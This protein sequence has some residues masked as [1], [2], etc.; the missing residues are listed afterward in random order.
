MPPP[1]PPLPMGDATGDG[2]VKRAGMETDGGED[3]LS[4]LPDD[5]LS[6]IL[7]R[8]GSTASAGQTSLLSRRWRR[9][10]SR[11]P[12]LLF[13]FPS[14]PAC[15]GPGIAANTAPFLRHV[16]VVCCDAPAGATTTWLHLLAPRVALDGVVYFRNTL[17]RRRVM[18]VAVVRGEPG[19]PHRHRGVGIVSPTYELPC[20]AT[21]AKLW[22]RLEFLNLEL[23]RSG[24]FA[25]L[26]ELFL[27]HVD[28]NHKGRGNFGH[29]FSTLRCPLL[30]RLRIAMCTGVDTLGIYSESLHHFELEFVPGLMELTLLTPNLRMLEVLSCFY[31]IEEWNCSIHAPDLESLRWGDRFNLD[32]VLFVDFACFQQLAAFT[33]PVYGRPDNTIILEFALLLRHFSAVYRLDLL[34]S[35]ERD[36]DKYEYLMEYITKL[37]IMNTMSLWLYTRGHSVGTS[38]FYLLSLCP[39]VKRLQLT[40]L[41]GIVANSPCHPHCECDQHP[42]WSE[43]E[44]IVHGLEEAEIRNF[45]GTKHDFNFVALLFLVAPALKKMTVTLDCMATSEE[46]CQKLREIVADRPGAC[47]E[48]HQNTSGVFYEFRQS[49]FTKTP[50]DHYYGPPELASRRGPWPP[51]LRDRG[52]ADRPTPPASLS[53]RHAARCLSGEL[54]WVNEAPAED[55]EGLAVDR[56]VFELPCLQN[57]T[58]IRCRALK[59][60]VLRRLTIVA[61]IH[62]HFH[63]PCDLGDAFSS[64]C[65]PSLIDLSI[66]GSDGV[67]SLTVYSQSLDVIELVDLSA[68]QCFKW[69]KPIA[70]INVPA[71][72]ELFEWMEPY[73]PSSV[74]L[75]DM[76]NLTLLRTH[77]SVF[78]PPGS[79]FNQHCA[80]LLR[81]FD[82]NSLDLLLGYPP[83]L[84]NNQCMMGDITMLPHVEKLFLSLS[85][86]PHA[87][88]ACVFHVLQMCTGVPSECPL[89]CICD[90]PDDWKTERISLDLLKEVEVHGIV[91]GEDEVAFLRQ[92]FRSA[93]DLKMMDAGKI[94]E[95]K[96]IWKILSKRDMV[97]QSSESLIF[98]RNKK[99][100]THNMPYIWNIA[101][102][103]ISAFLF[104]TAYISLIADTLG[105]K[106]GEEKEDGILQDK[107]RV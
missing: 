84:D 28:F 95:I 22:L 74:Q 62:V 87:F 48:I 18:A 15:V 24:V 20:F 94:E 23:P 50:D 75:N 103:C 17:S 30:R 65:C 63:G 104:G 80:M 13:P 72:L 57:A 32:S 52:R 6:S 66:L 49:N 61:L 102:I 55:E 3:R 45:R 35:Y 106:H 11:L 21:A 105:P 4:T 2:E 53:G 67:D 40:L 41:D 68:S 8:L 59:S 82:V 73:D 101:G 33:I 79:L 42:D 43:W 14:T 34:L 46:S 10:P 93:T 97:K 85:S 25:R 64:H 5:L 96:R 56:G 89:G 36:L 31:Y 38:V 51:P 69:N 92:L 16:D 19:G 39:G 47:L 98:E 83:S 100:G 60:G 71:A 91:G 54:S 58:K 1:P 86:R 77:L 29:T 81:L 9:L 44:A 27:E 37:P 78:E 7:L 12:R 88:G 70:N 99:M 76:L 26:T 107:K 90:Q